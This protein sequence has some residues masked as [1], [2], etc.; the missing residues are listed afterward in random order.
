VKRYA[1]AVTCNSRTSRSISTTAIAPSRL[2]K[3]R[4]EAASARNK[5]LGLALAGQLHGLLHPS[6]K[7]SFVELVVLVDVEV[8][9]FLVLGL[10]RGSGRSDVPE[11]SHL[12]VPR[13][14]MKAEEP[15]LALNAIEGRVPL[16]CVFR[17]LPLYTVRMGAGA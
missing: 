15:P 12:D 1:R 6:G 4:C 9:Q 10:A 5:L 14:A 16:D 17:F 3:P 13:Q 11:E 8:A 7:L 2:S